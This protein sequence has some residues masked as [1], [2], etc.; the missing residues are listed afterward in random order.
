MSRSHLAFLSL[1]S[2]LFVITCSFV[3]L[4]ERGDH[5]SFTHCLSSTSHS[6][7]HIVGIHLKYA[8]C[9]GNVSV[10]SLS[11]FPPWQWVSRYWKYSSNGEIR[12][13]IPLCPYHSLLWWLSLRHTLHCFAVTVC[14]IIN[15]FRAEWITFWS[16]WHGPIACTQGVIYVWVQ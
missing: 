3:S 16:L 9:V 10:L 13:S 11:V 4:C 14:M 12:V 1:H 15:S 2:S 7:W 5:V 8:Q 6:T